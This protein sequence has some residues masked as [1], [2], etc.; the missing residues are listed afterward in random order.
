MIRKPEVDTALHTMGVE[1]VVL[2][3]H[4]RLQEQLEFEEQVDDEQHD[5]HDFQ[6]AEVEVH[7]L[8]QVVAEVPVKSGCERYAE[9]PGIVGDVG[10]SAVVLYEEHA[11][12]RDVSEVLLGQ[13]LQSDV[14]QELSK[15]VQQVV[16]VSLQVPS[17]SRGLRVVVPV[18]VEVVVDDD[19]PECAQQDEMVVEQ[20]GPQDDGQQ[21]EE[22]VE[23]DV[24]EVVE[25]VS[26]KSEV[27]ELGCF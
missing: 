3:G 17:G 16:C 14:L 25:R 5:E 9:E 18:V 7:R 23:H 15:A 26:W 6:S 21:A 12:R 24:A 19:E 27:E 2:P 22:R 8:E 1:L 11:Q 20:Q 10:Y 13:E 4:E